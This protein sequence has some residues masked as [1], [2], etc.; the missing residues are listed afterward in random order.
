MRSICR[1]LDTELELNSLIKL[2]TMKKVYA[3]LLFVAAFHTDT[4]TA[5]KWHQSFESRELNRNVEYRGYYNRGGY[6]NYYAHQ[7]YYYQ[8][9]LFYNPAPLLGYNNFQYG[10]KRVGYY[11]YPGLNVYFNPNN[12][13][14]I[15]PSRGVWVTAPVL[16]R[17]F[18]INEPIRQVYCGVGENIWAYNRAHINTYRRAPVYVERGNGGDRFRER[19]TF[20]G[21]R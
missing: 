12:H 15:Y 4:A 11:F 13:L 19:E 6:C 16:P 14:Y 21:R 3:F 5:A 10:S 7:G 8:P 2:I 18:V 17:A 9:H 20:R 1:K